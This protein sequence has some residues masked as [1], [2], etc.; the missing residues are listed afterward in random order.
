[1]QVSFKDWLLADLELIF[2]IIF[3]SLISRAVRSTDFRITGVELDDQAKALVSDAH[4]HT[5]RI[6]AR[7]PRS[8]SSK[9]CDKVCPLFLLTGDF[10]RRDYEGSHL[11]PC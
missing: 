11:G 5:V 1:M 10:E 8:S 9:N 3:M 2:T 7:H 6:I 4:N